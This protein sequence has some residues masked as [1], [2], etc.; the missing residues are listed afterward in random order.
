[1]YQKNPIVGDSQPSF[2]TSEG[3]IFS[4]LKSP[5]S[6]YFNDCIIPIDLH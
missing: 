3:V 2:P 6:D 4:L 1:M 5:V